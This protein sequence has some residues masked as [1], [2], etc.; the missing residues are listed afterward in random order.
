M[1]T[2]RFSVSSSNFIRAFCDFIFIYVSTLRSGTREVERHLH[3]SN[4]P[5]SQPWDL[6]PYY[7]ADS[8]A[9]GGIVPALLEPLSA[10]EH[11]ESTYIGSF[12]MTFKR[13]IRLSPGKLLR[14]AWLFSIHI[15][16][17]IAFALKAA[18]AQRGFT[19]PTLRLGVSARV[20]PCVAAEPAVLPPP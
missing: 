3:S 13:C 12:L 5:P 4:P 18:P 15:K 19:L 8:T 7:N 6:R 10:R 9:K 2:N 17:L 20:R 16:P 11:G 1:L 14:A